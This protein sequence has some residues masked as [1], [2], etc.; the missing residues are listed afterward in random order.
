MPDAEDIFYEG[1]IGALY[2]FMDIA[3]RV[4]AIVLARMSA[5]RRDAHA[6]QGAVVMGIGRG[7]GWR[8]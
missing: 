6:M 1:F 4:T 5:Q 8:S 7:H 3:A 2:P